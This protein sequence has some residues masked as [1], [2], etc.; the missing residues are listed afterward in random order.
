MITLAFSYNEVKNTHTYE[1]TCV[2]SGGKPFIKDVTDTF[3]NIASPADILI[4]PDTSGGPLYRDD[5]I[6]MIFRDP[7]TRQFTEDNI[8]EQIAELNSITLTAQTGA[9]LFSKIDP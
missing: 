1:L 6:T 5:T 8:T 2:A 3:L 9:V 7:A 4:I